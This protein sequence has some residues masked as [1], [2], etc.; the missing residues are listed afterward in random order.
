MDVGLRSQIAQKRQ[1][2]RNRLRY[3]IALGC[4]SVL[5]AGIGLLS[6]CNRAYYRNQ[7]DEETYAIIDQKAAC[8]NDGSV[9]RLPVDPRSRMF[10]PFNPDRPPM[11]EDD[12]IAHHYMEIIDKKKHYPLWDVNGRTNTA[13][14]PVWWQYLPLDERGVMVLDAE[15]AVQL[16]LLHNPTYQSE[17]ETL[18]LSAIDVSSERFLFDTQFFAGSSI[19]WSTTGPK[20]PGNAGESRSNLAVGPFSRG[21]R[22]MAIQKR[23]ATGADL[24]IGMAN[25][26]T[27]QLSGPDTQ[28][29][30]TLLDFSFVQPLLKAG[31]RDVVLERL[32]LAERTLLYNVRAF[33]RYKR[34]F[35]CQVM[36]G[37]NAEAGPT[38]RG[39]LFGGA[40]LE[41]F[42]GLGGGFGRVGN[43]TGAGTGF[44]ATANVPR[45]GGFFG[46]LQNQL[47][48][49]NAEEN[50]A[51]LRD[52]LLRF[53]DT[54]REQLTT[55]P[56]TQD[57]IPSQ[58]LQVAQARQALISAQ[59]N[60][61]QTRA[62]YEQSLDTFKVLLGLPPYIC[63]EIRDPFL[64][65]FEL[66][67]NS[68]KQR[69]D[70]VARVRDAIGQNNS[71][72][73]ALSKTGRDDATGESYREIK[74]SP[75]VVAEI[76]GIDGKIDQI[77]DLRRKILDNDIPEIASDITK[78]AKVKDQRKQQL[79]AM[80]KRYYEEREMICALLPTGTLDPGLFDTTELDTLPET[81]DAD[82]KRLTKK[83]EGYRE[84]VDELDKQVDLLIQENLGTPRQTFAEIRDRAILRGQDIL[85]GFAEDVLA[86]QVLQAR[87][88]TEAVILPEVN[89]SARDA[90]EIARYN[91]VDW[92]NTRAGLVD[93]WRA[94]EIV[95]DDLESS[96]DVVF[97]GD[98][99]NVNDNPLSLRGN[100]GR[101]RAGLQWDAPIT[102]LQ[103]R[104]RYRQALIE[105]QQA[106]RSYYQFEDG[107]W[108]TLRTELRGIHQNQL[109]FELQRYA[110]RM[111]ASQITLT[112]D[113]RQIREALSQASGPTAARD[114]VSAL[115]DLLNAQNTFQ[116]VWVF[117]ELLRR[118]LDMDLGT[119]QLDAGGM[120][121]DPGT[122]TMESFYQPAPI[123]QNYLQQLPADLQ[124]EEAGIRRPEPPQPP[125]DGAFTY[126]PSNTG[127]I[128]AASML[129]STATP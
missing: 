89:L 104:N 7:A 88:R 127:T 72:L 114:S 109:N 67:S 12:P 31:G 97:S 121:M 37:R 47:E 9:Q 123:E 64:S 92:A 43:T 54:L 40:G 39:G 78:L 13:E 82:L 29:A 24:V 45:A 41:G 95:A 60:L 106:K 22:P 117:Y 49:R 23:F 5:L 105:Y 16:A 27:W 115:S 11:P 44:A 102:R 59:A 68:L 85:A 10:D 20:R 76:R 38:R 57:T 15:T 36:I 4:S 62:N 52:N 50:I 26:I 113:I 83:I 129:Q 124:R 81:L 120:W 34:G 101:L 112:E 122:I 58:Q 128:Q 73:L 77:I 6:G 30:S 8:T 103:E 14:N 2:R 86:L 107:I 125:V 79:A 69:R 96:L 17:V 75:D 100:A 18:Y 28:T 111:A 116:G 3:Y 87:A 56:A 74:M 71:Q 25:T 51:R 1:T 98:V 90:V 118:N 126:D 65:Q 21:R 84:K 108:N 91:R 46:L 48:I 35:Y 70:D 94:I 80:K 93:S 66:I 32:T 55:V 119:M 63:T 19:D 110:V 61:L 53:E 99:V 33:E 42:T